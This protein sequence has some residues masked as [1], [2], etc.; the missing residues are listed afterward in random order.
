MNTDQTEPDDRLVEIDGPPRLTTFAHV[1]LPYRDLAEGKRFYV[2]VLGGQRLTSQASYAA[3]GLAGIRLGLGT[4]GC[5]FISPQM[6]YPNIAFYVSAD[7]MRQLRRWLARCR[8]PVSR[9]WTRTGVEAL[10]FIRDP[11]GNL[12]EFFCKSGFPGAQA[13]PRGGARAGEATDIDSLYYT[14]WCS[15]TQ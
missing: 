4:D 2:E 11:S 6:E 8:V 12:I 3:I 1:S 14:D 5:S 10:M 9:L 13:L 15:P 7:E